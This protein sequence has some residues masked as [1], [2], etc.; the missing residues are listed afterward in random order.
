[1]ALYMKTPWQNGD[2][3]AKGY[4]KWTELLAFSWGTVRPI[5][6]DG[7]AGGGGAGRTTFTS[8]TISKETDRTTVDFGR[9]VSKG[10]PVNLTIAKVA[11]GAT[12]QEVERFDIYRAWVEDQSF[13]GGPDSRTQESISL[14]FERH[15]SEISYVEG[16]PVSKWAFNQVTGT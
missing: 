7:G 16:A 3:T 11:T 10:G 4:E 6:I 8:L 1:M 9:S 15:V 2:V 12:F 13:S 14:V 5:S